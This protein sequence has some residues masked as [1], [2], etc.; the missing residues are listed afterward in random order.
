MKRLVALA[1]ASALTLAPR[2]APADDADARTHFAAGVGLYDK[3]SY[4]PALAEFE[5]AY[6]AKR[7]PQIKRNIALCLRGLGRYPE[8]ID[9]LE[10]MLVEAGDALKPEV[11]DGA[12]QAIAEMTALV[13]TLRV[14]VV[15]TGRTPPV[16]VAVSI[17]ERPVPEAHLTRPLR[18]LPG[19]HVL[20]AAATGYFQAEQKVRVTAGQ[21]ETTVELGLVAVEI[22]PRGRLTV[23]TNVPTAHIVLDG[24]DVGAGS[25][26]GDV[27]AGLHRVDATAEGYPHHSATVSVREGAQESLSLDMASRPDGEPELIAPRVVHLWYVT[28][29]LG[30]QG[31][32]LTPTAGV[33]DDTGTTTRDFAGGSL[34]VHLGRALGRHVA[35][36]GVAELGGL[37]SGPYASATSPTT[38]DTVNLTRFAVGPELRVH[39]AGKLRAYAGLSF[40]LVGQ[41]ISATLGSASGSTARTLKGSGGAGFAALEAG[42]QYEMGRVFLEASLFANLHGVAAVDANQNRFFADSP[43]VGGGLRAS[44]GY[45]F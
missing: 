27:P 26:T 3:K 12:R 17:D 40:G 20:K 18:L 35:L 19:D 43:V 23:Q 6:A 11:K 38:R 9:A 28:G 39:T 7:S 21:P 2:V 42:G 8:A 32:S 4:A 15:S 5:L 13:A 31:E 22:A 37:S 25:W 33:L 30:L 41:G 29:G 24:V 1:L 36:G 10:E 14:R 44:V 45:T 34:V 16:A